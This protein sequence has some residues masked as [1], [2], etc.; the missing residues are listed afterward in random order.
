MNW[1]FPIRLL[2]LCVTLVTLTS[3]LGDGSKII[4]ESNRSGNNDIFSVS[5]TGDNL[6]NLTNTS[7]DNESSAS[8]S[9]DGSEIVFTSN[10]VNGIGQWDMKLMIMEHDGAN[11]QMLFGGAPIENP[12]WSPSGDRIVFLKRFPQGAYLEF[13]GVSRDATGVWAQP[14]LICPSTSG[15]VTEF[16]NIR[17][18]TVFYGEDHIIFD[19]MAPLSIYRLNLNTCDIEEFE[20][21]YDDI[22]YEPDVTAGGK[23]VWVRNDNNVQ[24]LYVRDSFLAG[25][26]SI[27]NSTD[28]FPHMPSWSHNEEFIS[29]WSNSSAQG[30]GSIKVYN[31]ITGGVATMSSTIPVRASE[32]SSPLQRW[33]P[34]DEKMVF[35]GMNEGDTDFL[36]DEVYVLDVVNDEIVNISNNA[37]AFDANPRWQPMESDTI[38]S[39][40]VDFESVPL[41][42]QYH[43]QDSFSDSGAV[44]TVEAFQSGGGSWNSDDYVEAIASE[45]TNFGKSIKIDNMVLRIDIG[46]VATNGLTFIFSETGGNINMT[47]NGEFRNVDN[48]ADL[49]G[50]TIGGTT[51]LVQ[52]GGGNDAGAVALNG[53]VNSFSVGGQELI[54]DQVCAH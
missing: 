12:E 6:T 40:C 39:G 34:N 23:I 26:V 5:P 52:N 30:P 47:V 3:C 48:F 8:W 54:V 15:F 44:M 16:N 18:R 31:T 36:S 46:V 21:N 25:S 43:F 14:Q 22:Q 19:G 13:Y 32:G 20:P 1:H 27:L 29:F 45:S 37:A 28:P 7:D 51:V 17:T 9:P 35:V 24:S 11:Q 38:F 50:Q 33:S 53:E 2:A 4:F 42:A 49:N 41:G 10:P